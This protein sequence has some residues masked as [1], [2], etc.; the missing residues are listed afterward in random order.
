MA[1]G[2]MATAVASHRAGHLDD[3][4]RGYRQMLV[5]NPRD[6]DALHLLGTIAVQ[7]GRWNE[8]IASLR[9]AKRQR[10]EDPEILSVLGVAEMESGDLGAAIATLRRA[11]EIAPRHVDALINLANALRRAGWHAE[12]E[13]TYRKA[14]VIAPG[15][16]LALNGLGASIALRGDHAGAV[17]VLKA[18]VRAAPGFADAHNNLGRA[19]QGLEQTDE[20]KAA[21]QCA[22]LLDPKNLDALCNLGALLEEAGDLAGAE[23]RYREALE[24]SPGF[25]PAHLNLGNLRRRR[26][27]AAAALAEYQAA[28]AADPRYAE[29]LN[30]LGNLL[31]DLRRYDEALAAFDQA[32]AL[33]PKS[34]ETLANRAKTL[35][36]MGRLEEA[37]ALYDRALDLGPAQRDARFGRALT[38][39]L[40][41][42]F[43]SKA[44]ATAWSDYLARDSMARA[45]GRFDRAP[46]PHDLAGKRILIERDQGLGDE[47]FF[48]R[49][50][51]ALRRRGAFVAYRAEPRLVAMV[52]RSGVVDATAADGA[53]EEGFD[54]RLAIGDLPHVLGPE[55]IAEGSCPPTIRLTPT[56]DRDAAARAQLAALGPPPYTAMTWRA[57]TPDRER[58]LFKEIP[59]DRLA[60]SLGAAP[61]TLVA[62]QRHPRPNEI[63]DLGRLA[64]RKV[65]D[66]TALNDDLELMLAVLGR[67]D[68]YVAVSNTNV[69]LRAARGRASRILVPH[70]PEFRW[71]AAGARSPWFPDCALYRQAADGDW[72]AALAALARDLG[73]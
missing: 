23:A 50:V 6:A 27:D 68:D 21:F 40:S 5:M 7:R 45:S 8:A 2:V 72:N 57:G 46:L 44:Y 10:P 64:G 54:F 17:A 3:A 14:G 19:Y 35:R 16:P 1:Q 49:F 53:S 34:A 9:S 30:N 25:P 65:A 15:H 39:L 52:D 73:S 59:L 12:A 18:A 31:A 55:P 29:A 67:L 62:L 71:L 66:L 11:A 36:A 13:A 26:G 47:L 58:S 63:A 69:H 41:G 32:A 22:L 33:R 70:P 42:N 60:R 38:R 51:G 56:A 48:L 37:V 61:G 4:E 24:I 28:L 20:A 43:S